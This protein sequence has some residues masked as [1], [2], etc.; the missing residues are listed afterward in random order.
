[1]K[2]SGRDDH[3]PESPFLDSS[4]AKYIFIQARKDKPGYYSPATII[5]KGDLQ[6]PDL[7]DIG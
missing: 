5:R 2:Y 1:M 3:L 7:L 4:K 6:L